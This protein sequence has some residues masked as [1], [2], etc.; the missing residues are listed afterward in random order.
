VATKAS[1]PRAGHDNQAI[2]TN[3]G[4][5]RRS[6]I[7]I[8]PIGPGLVMRHADGTVAVRPLA[9]SDRYVNSS[10]SI[11]INKPSCQVPSRPRS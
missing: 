2:V 3:A 7:G 9:V 10:G 5:N 6:G 8:C 1:P 4:G 11:S